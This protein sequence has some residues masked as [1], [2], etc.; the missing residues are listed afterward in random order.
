MKTVLKKL[1]LV[2]EAIPSVKKDSKNP[3][4]KNTY[5]SLESV[6]ETVKPILHLHG[7]LLIQAIDATENGAIIKTTIYD[8]ETEEKIVSETPIL[9]GK[10][11][12]PQSFF[13]GT[14]YSRRYAILSLLAIPTDDDDGNTASMPQ[15]TV[16]TANT[17]V[18]TQPTTPA[19]MSDNEM[20]K[21]NAGT[22]TNKPAQKPLG[23]NK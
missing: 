15:N 12:D 3:H 20:Y 6:L 2:Q 16:K 21:G 4:F 10:P 7:L 23:S 5:A 18:K 17:P 19:K 11:N 9:Y 1:L 8:P 13:G 22:L 14:T